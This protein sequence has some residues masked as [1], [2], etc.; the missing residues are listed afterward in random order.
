MFG[1]TPRRAVGAMAF[2]AVL[3]PAVVHAQTIPADQLDPLVF[4]HIGPVGNRLASVAGVAG[5]PLTYYVGAASGGLWK[6]DDGGINWRPLFEEMDVH[7]VGALAVAPSDP[8]IVWAGTGEPHIRSNVTIGDGIYRS[9]DGGEHW[10]HM[11]LDATGRISRIVVHP[12]NP[13]IVYA[14][15]VGHAHAPQRE[16]GIFR[17]VDGGKTWEHVLF[18]DEN[19]GASSLIMDPNNPRILFAGMWQIRVNT[20]GR[21][22]GGPGSGIFM[23]RDG[24]STWTRL[25]GHGLPTLPVGKIDV[26]MSGADSRMIY[27]LIETGDGV[28][29][30]GQETESGELWRSENGGY[31]WRLVNHSR[32]LG[33]R[34]A[35]YNNCRVSTADPHEVYFL[36]AGFSRTL[37]GGVTYRNEFGLRRPGGD[38]H[39]MWI[40]PTDADRMIV[41]H[42]QGLSISRN[43]GET[44]HRVELPVGQMY[45]VTADNAIPYNVMGNRQDGP[46]ARGPSNTRDGPFI[47]RGYWETVGGGESGF[48]TPDP[49][50]P[51]I[52]WSSASGSG[53]RGGIVVRWDARNRQFRNVE[54]WPESTGGW[55][56]EDLRYRFQWTFPLLISPHDRNTIFVTSQHVHRTRNG[57][58]SWD[59]ISPDLTTNDKSRQGISGGLTPDNIGV[60]YCCVIYAFDESP[61]QEG[62]FYAGSNDGKVHVS[63]DGGEVWTDVT[64]NFPGWPE[65]GVVRGIDASRWDAG[66]AYLVVE[67]HQV[68]DFAPYVYKTENYGAGWTRITH[69]IADHPLSFTRSIQE[70]PVRPGLLYLGTENRIY[71]SF[72]DGANWQP[73]V[74]NMPPSPMYGIV[75]QEHF[76][77]LVIGTYGRGFWI[78][79]DLT[80]LQ[81]LDGEVRNASAYLFQPRDAYRFASTTGRF[82]PMPG[83]Q[84]AGTNPPYGAS[85]N[86]WLGDG[87]AGPAT[88]TISNEAGDVVRTMTGTTEAGLNRVWW[89]LRDGGTERIR[90]RTTPLYA[91]WIDLG[92]ERVIDRGRGP[93][94]LQAPGRYTVTLTVAGESFTKTLNVLKDPNSE[95]TLA[96]IRA[97]VA[98]MEEIQ[99]DFESAAEAVNRIEWLRRQLLDLSAV[100]EDQ[101]GADDVVGEAGRLGDLLIAIEEQLVQLRTTGTGQ[102]GVRYPARAVEQLSHLANGVGTADFGPSDQQGEVRTL[103]RTRIDA[104]RGQLDAFIAD[105]LARFNR[106]LREQGLNPLISE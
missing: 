27:A 20:W 103:I 106:L 78:M 100:L 17:T 82:R 87:V 28:P 57:G 25:K 92:S 76:N 33:G 22:S 79:D 40:D 96:D 81:Q 88:L 67:A 34:T 35:Y 90:M 11:G 18:V 41:V 86:Y 64:A 52:V 102:D 105:E 68:G 65:D 46:S 15:S 3:T 23:S 89:D 101:G 62:V 99:S 21:E 69:G 71:V 39:D 58:Q 84:T 36:T 56:A 50:D 63:R 60:E 44:W 8:Q 32:D 38:H 45:H 7:S 59:V 66:K 19:T 30:H 26:C 104:A 42:D 54:V 61:V 49:E 1:Q 94:V 12:T 72:D 2:V 51:D 10:E 55:P 53:A 83:D 24:G 70:D 75:V 14:A 74:N 37:D 93:S 85:I 6:T 77:D 73:L 16:R 31:D 80:P 9:A 95:G 29:W 91:D 5:D 97:Q 47:P 43:R 13:D 98:A 4:R 48:A